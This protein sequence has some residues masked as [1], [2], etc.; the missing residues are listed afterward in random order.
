VDNEEEQLR[1]EEKAVRE[2]LFDLLKHVSTLNVAALVLTLALLQD[3]PPTGLHP[4]VEDMPLAVFGVSLLASMF[5]PAFAPWNRPPGV[6]AAVAIT[7]SY[8]MFFCGVLI[9]IIVGMVAL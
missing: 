6:L 4:V 2:R 5:G 8:L 3:F 7:V 9:T 1:E